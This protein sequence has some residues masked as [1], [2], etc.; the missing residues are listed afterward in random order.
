MAGV[1]R[2]FIIPHEYSNY[3]LD[4]LCHCHYKNLWI[5][6]DV[7]PS[8]KII[9]RITIYTSDIPCI[10]KCENCG[11][12]YR[13]ERDP[14]PSLTDCGVEKKSRWACRHCKDIDECTK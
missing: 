11:R 5:E 3:T 6:S 12:E 13:I 1:T 4:F 7:I 14:K 9:G 8:A 2:I 10:V